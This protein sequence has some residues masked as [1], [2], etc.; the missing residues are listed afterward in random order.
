ML[1]SR[2]H[3][4]IN[5]KGTNLIIFTPKC[6]LM[7]HNFKIHFDCYFFGLN[8]FFWEGEISCLHCK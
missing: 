2:K 5:H 4:Q 3:D 7:S 1:T 8:V 6:V